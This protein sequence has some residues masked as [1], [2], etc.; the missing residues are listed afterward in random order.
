M[1]CDDARYDLFLVSDGEQLPPERSRQ[2][3]E[4]LAECDSCKAFQELNELIDQA[5][6]S[7]AA[8]AHCLDA[9]DPLVKRVT[10]AVM[11]RLRDQAPG[12]NEPPAV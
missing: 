8:Q 12:S 2:L 6:A 1:K 5:V 7:Y 10:A 11:A 4:H 9:D 3:A